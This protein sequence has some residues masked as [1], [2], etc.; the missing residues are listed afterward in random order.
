MASDGIMKHFWFKD[1]SL[2]APSSQYA[3]ML[4]ELTTYTRTGKVPHD[5]SPDGLA[6]LENEVRNL[7]GNNVRIFA[8]PY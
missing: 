5:D 1:R 7:S 2:Y 6:M 4:K 8:R 3:L